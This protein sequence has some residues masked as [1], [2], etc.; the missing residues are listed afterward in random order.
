MPLMAF[1]ACPPCVA[2]GKTTAIL[3]Q[4]M[5][6]MTPRHCGHT[7]SQ[8]LSKVCSVCHSCHR[9]NC[10][11]SGKIAAMTLGKV[12]RGRRTPMTRTHR[13][14]VLRMCASLKTGLTD[15]HPV[16][17]LLEVRAKSAKGCGS[18]SQTEMERQGS[19]SLKKQN[20]QC[21]R[22]KFPSTRS[23][24]RSLQREVQSALVPRGT[25]RR[26]RASFM[27]RAHAMLGLLATFTMIQ[28]SRG[29][30]RIQRRRLFREREPPRWETCLPLQR[31]R[32][33]RA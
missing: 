33:H 4:A 27:P 3:A 13:Q 21:R 32:C 6:T 25:T 12:Q 14:D 18:N 31:S 7:T 20:R 10:H 26:S 11:C 17:L 5:G 2:V 30:P 29:S 24:T 9:T 16:H 19:L 15:F 1:P 8:L 22:T 28:R 23:L